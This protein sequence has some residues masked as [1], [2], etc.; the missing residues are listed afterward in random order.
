MSTGEF[1]SGLFAK[2]RLGED[3]GLTKNRAR[4]YAVIGEPP[5]LYKSFLEPLSKAHVE[6]LR[7]LVE[8][9]RRVASGEIRRAARRI[10][11]PVDLVVERGTLAGVLIP[12]AGAEYFRPGTAQ[13]VGQSFSH[14]AHP[15]SAPTVRVRLLVVRQLADALAMLAEQGYVHG[16][17]SSAN[18]LW[19][20][21]RE[22]SLLLVDCDGLHP[23]GFPTLAFNTEYW[24]DPRLEAEAI[25]R[26]DAQSDWYAL[27]LAVYRVLVLN[28]IA[29]PRVRDFDQIRGQLPS[30]LAEPIVRVFSDPLDAEA[31]VAPTDWTRALRVVIADPAQ[32]ELIDALTRGRPANVGDRRRAHAAAQAKAQPPRD[33]EPAPQPLSWRPAPGP[34][35]PRQPPRSSSSGAQVG[36]NGLGSRAPRRPR[37]GHTGRSLLKSLVLFAILAAV[38]IFGLYHFTGL[39]NWPILNELNPFLSSSQR[40]LVASLPAAAHHC[41]GGE[42]APPR[43]AVAM[44]SCEWDEREV[45]AIQFASVHALDGFYD[46]RLRVARAKMAGRTWPSRC[47]A[48]GR[49]HATGDHHSQGAVTSFLSRTGARLDW[50]QTGT[51]IYFMGF[52]IDRDLAALCRWWKGLGFA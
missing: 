14:L 18:M 24:K 22:P 26:H 50:S 6:R 52:R 31:R 39:P 12:R 10:V 9:G 43:G 5:L 8:V 47:P 25:R 51:R 35:Q 2:Y 19:T 44:V 37:G 7:E 32:R 41:E 27:A 45:V 16:D 4:L 38:G 30:A 11:W 46:K 17:I 13:P 42:S 21:A 40:E 28:P 20:L 36:A 34:L 49:W 23:R 15:S 3:T 29:V 33:P 48:S 1:V